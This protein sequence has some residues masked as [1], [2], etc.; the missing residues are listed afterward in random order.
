MTEISALGNVTCQI[1]KMTGM[2]NLRPW[3]ISLNDVMLFLFQSIK[4]KNLQ[5][6]KFQR[7]AYTQ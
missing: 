1:G 2:L 4:K 3:Y 7:V 5:V 6:T